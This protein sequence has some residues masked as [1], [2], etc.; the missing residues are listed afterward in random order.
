MSNEA[1]ACPLMH[2]NSNEI[3]SDDDD[4]DDDV[5]FYKDDD[6]SKKN[7]YIEQSQYLGEVKPWFNRRNLLIT[8]VLGSLVILY[9]LLKMF[10]QQESS[11]ADK[12]PLII[13]SSIP[14]KNIVFFLVD[15]LG[16]NDIGYNSFDIAAASPYMTK[17][18]QEGIIFTNYYTYSQCTPTRA[19]LLTGMY[20]S[21]IGMQHDC[22]TSC[23]PFGVPLSNILLPAFLKM[24]N[25]YVTAMV[26]KW[27]IGHYYE[28]LWPT[29]RGFD[30]S[31]HLLCYGYLEYTQHIGSA[32]FY[33]LHDG[34]VKIKTGDRIR[35]IDNM[36]DPYSTLIFTERSLAI[37]KEHSQ[38]L[39]NTYN[40]DGDFDSLLDGSKYNKII[41][42]E[43]DDD[44]KGEE[45]ENEEVIFDPALFL[46]V[47]W[48]AV[49]TTL[50]VPKGYNLTAEYAYITEFVDK[51]YNPTRAVLAG[52]LKVVDAGFKLI[53]DQLKQ[54]NLFE[55]TLVIVASDNGGSVD[56][57]GNNY[58]LRG[59]KRSNFDGGMKVP[60]FMFSPLLPA[61][62]RGSVY[63]DLFHV[64]DWLPTLAYG[65][66]ELTVINGFDGVDHWF[67][68]TDQ[69][70]VIT[71]NEDGD[72]AVRY[73]TSS[74]DDDDGTLSGTVL[75][76]KNPVRTEITCALDYLT[77]SWQLSAAHG[78]TTEASDTIIESTGCI[79]MQVSSSALNI[80]DDVYDDN[81]FTKNDISDQTN[82]N[83]DDDEKVALYKFLWNQEFIN[84][85]YPRLI[86]ENF[87]NSSDLPMSRERGGA[88]LFELNSDPYEQT[89]LLWHL[90]NSETS[91]HDKVV[92]ETIL[93]NFVDKFCSEYTTEM[94]PA[95]WK[96]KQGF[97]KKLFSEN[98]RFITHW[99]DEEWTKSDFAASDGTITGAECRTDEVMNLIYS[100]TRYSSA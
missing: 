46:F 15:D 1:Q 75:S 57:G 77:Q 62:K 10:R 17:A 98:E 69:D 72:A 37:I 94:V 51:G 19:S 64:C 35:G 33:D 100:D 61:Y 80:L 11:K 66:Q 92:L 68:F 9:P 99:I 18:A 81:V 41:Y 49:H 13:R 63:S 87:Y 91:D 3:I 70:V 84:W 82:N 29:K 55:N 24:N 83:N 97:A 73:T 47:A 8:V 40:M 93:L 58:P 4:N 44:E 25:Q 20:S 27:D 26:G 21:S 6:K 30:N 22:I 39:Q 71:T 74:H 96:K 52:A 12:E 23:D 38:R 95:L 60:A 16:Y 54:E 14:P 28:M 48:N 43:V 50:S 67:K 65:L 79:I 90:D 34:F 36:G 53:V 7:K 45:G 85:L 5:S 2:R 89:N 56:D 78:G 88:Y 86:P 42:K 32:G 31:L 76:P 59:G